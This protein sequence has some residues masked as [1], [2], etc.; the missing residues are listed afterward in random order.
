MPIRD[1]CGGRFCGSRSD[2]AETVLIYCAAAPIVAL[3]A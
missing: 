3:K 2:L 1:F